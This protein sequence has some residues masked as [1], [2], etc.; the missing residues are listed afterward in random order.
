GEADLST[1]FPGVLLAQHTE[2]VTEIQKLPA[3]MIPEPLRAMQPEIAF[4]A[5][6]R[7]RFKGVLVMIGERSI[8]VSNP[9]PYLGWD[10][11]KP[12]IVEVFT[13]LLKSSLVK[14]VERYSLKY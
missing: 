14:R 9:A 4:V 3:A 5:L 7:L 2:D 1:V 13:A 6:V 11:F 12:L 8:T 10:K